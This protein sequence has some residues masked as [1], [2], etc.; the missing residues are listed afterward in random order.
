LNNNV[1]QILNILMEKISDEEI[2][3]KKEELIQYLL[4]EGYPLE[5][6]D[7]A[8][9]LIFAQQQ[10][11]VIDLTPLAGVE[12][13][14]SR[15]RLLTAD[16]KMQLTREAVGV[17][18]QVQTS[19]LLDLQKWEYLLLTLFNDQEPP[20]DSSVLWQGLQKVLPEEDLAMLARLIPEFKPFMREAKF[21]IN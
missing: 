20:I 12:L 16:E 14:T 11:N 15:L 4:D 1:A 6:I 8:F 19:G 3:V 2:S 5:D 21:Y 13:S 9:Q 10:Q 18:L 7:T 17:L